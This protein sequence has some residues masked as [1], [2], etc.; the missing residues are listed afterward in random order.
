MKILVTG[1]AG[2]IGSHTSAELLQAGYDLVVIDN[3]SNS[4]P[5]ALR[6]IKTITNRDFS[7]YQGDVTDQSMLDEIFQ[8]HHIDGVIHFAGFKAVGESVQEPL[9]YYHN[10]ILSTLVLC[11]T[12]ARYGC[13]SIV[14]SSSATVYGNPSRLP[15]TEDF[16]LSATNPYGSSKLMIENI[17][18]D[19]FIS[20][21]TW[22]IALLRYF[23]PVGA[24]KSGLI[25]ENPKGI[26]N[27]LMPYIVKAAKGE[28]PH[29]NV[30]GDDYETRD[31]TG[32]R[33]YIHVVD[34]SIGHIKA[35]EKLALGSGIFT[36]N[37]GTGKG[38][39][40]LEMIT[41]FEKSTGQKVPYR[42]GKRRPGDIAAC[43]ADPGKAERELGWKAELDLEAMCR[44]AWYF[45]VKSDQI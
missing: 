21:Q 27:N 40:V 8:A 6:G 19:L 22:R 17:L 25:G 43:F 16:P 31:G 7:F 32:I 41:A 14:F 2:Y 42:V 45:S 36:Y 15:I 26:P 4:A 18:G 38:T 30:F 11:K 12:M 23:N 39:S 29:L 10:N 33:D 28:L 1:G 9:K 3:F 5:S 24:H 13:K 34:L 44:D 20:D 35:L 37:L